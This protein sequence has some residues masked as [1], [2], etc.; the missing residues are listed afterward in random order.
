MQPSYHDQPSYR[1]SGGGGGGGGG[2]GVVN[3]YL[4]ASSGS[5][6]SL[7]NIEEQLSDAIATIVFMP[8]KLDRTAQT[9]ADK[10]NSSA[11]D[12][13]TLAVGLV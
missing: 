11:N 3:P 5:A 8:T 9:I 4:N 7:Y 13:D 10:I 6:S 1:G 12:L 2:G